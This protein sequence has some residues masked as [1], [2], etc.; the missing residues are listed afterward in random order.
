V[1][2]D[3]KNYCLLPEAKDYKRIGEGDT[4]LNTGGMGAISPVPFVD[5]VF[6]QKVI[7]RIVEPTIQGL[8]KRNIPY[9]GFIF[10]GL[11]KVHHEPYV[12][13]YNCR[14]GDPETEVVMPRLEND[15]VELLM[16]L[17]DQQLYTIPCIHS[18]QHAAT[19]M[20]VSAGYPGAY[21]KGKV[22]QH[23]ESKAGSQLFHAGTKLEGTELVTQ[24][25]RV[26][27]IT[28]LAENLADALAQSKHLA[29]QISY[30]GKYYR[31]DIG[32]EFQ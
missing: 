16:S 12:I 14:M 20:L 9:Q 28:S 22:I 11:I 7:S 17:K 32:Y 25:G 23:V 5:S 19:I 4:G 6:M 30:E 13:E 27:A 18:S 2:T 21:E 8:Q 1:L 31:K 15:L 3:G 29:E 10:V 26:L 24:G